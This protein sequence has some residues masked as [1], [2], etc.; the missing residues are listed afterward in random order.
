MAVARILGARP[1]IRPAWGLVRCKCHTAVQ[2]L[3]RRRASHSGGAA[4]SHGQVGAGSGTAE[5]VKQI[6][7]SV[8]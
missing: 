8:A 2:P 4:N 7:M 5:S 6:G 1:W 3:W